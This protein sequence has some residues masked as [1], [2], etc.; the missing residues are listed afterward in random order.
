MHGIEARE[1]G[2]RRKPGRRRHVDDAEH[3]EAA[4]N[5]GHQRPV[6]DLERARDA[7][8]DQQHGDAREERG[9]A[10]QVD[11]GRIGGRRREPV[12]E[13]EEDRAGGGRRPR[14]PADLQEIQ[15]GVEPRPEGLAR[16]RAHEAGH[17]R[18]AGG[19][20][21]AHE[22]GVEDGLEEHRDQRHPQ[23]RQPVFDEGGRA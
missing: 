12:G 23:Q 17:H 13:Q 22:L 3:Q 6:E 20:R 15:H 11:S 14:R 9:D 16:P 2:E 21:V 1:P 5:A 19:D 8:A 10:D 7:F 4:E 18:L